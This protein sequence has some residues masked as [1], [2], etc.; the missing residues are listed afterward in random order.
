[1]ISI[2]FDSAE[3]DLHITI[4]G[5]NFRD[6]VDFVKLQGCRWNPDLKCWTLSVTK[7]DDFKEA[8]QSFDSVDIDMLTKTE[9]IRWKNSLV[10]LKVYR[11]TFKQEL[12]NMSPLVG[13]HPFEDYQI[14]D[15]TENKFLTRSIF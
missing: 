3:D 10:E 11:R 13:K 4:G 9:V 1:M 12:M 8:A 5:D 7:Y 6:L 14:A 15:I 2:S